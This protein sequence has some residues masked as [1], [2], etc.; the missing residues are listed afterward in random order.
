VA[1]LVATPDESGSAHTG[2]NRS[3]RNK[4]HSTVKQH[5][6]LEH[7]RIKK[8]ANKPGQDNSVASPTPPHYHQEHFGLD[9]NTRTMMVIWRVYKRLELHT[10]LEDNWLAPVIRQKSAKCAAHVLGVLRSLGDISPISAFLAM[11]L[12]WLLHDAFK[13]LP[14]KA[15]FTKG[16]ESS[17][18]K[19]RFSTTS[20]DATGDTYRD[21]TLLCAPL[22]EDPVHPACACPMDTHVGKVV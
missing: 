22:T 21:P 6:K 13:P 4:K 18:E 17:Q 12:K 7:Y 9:I 1:P 20:L 15:A 2:D 8:L 11:R 14:A 19:D 3:I 10:Y 16:F 5:C